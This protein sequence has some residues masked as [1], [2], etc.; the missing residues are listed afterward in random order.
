MYD[1]QTN[2]NLVQAFILF[3]RNKNLNQ[4]AKLLGIS[5]PALSRQ[6]MQFERD[7]GLSLFSNQGRKKVLSA[8]GQ[9]V[10]DKLNSK[11]VDYNEVFIQLR[12]EA[13]NSPVRPIEILGSSDMIGLF[14][15]KINFPFSLHYQFMSSQEVIS[16]LKENK[17]Q[18]GITKINTNRSDLIQK[19]FLKVDFLLLLLSIGCKETNF[20]S[21][22]KFL[23]KR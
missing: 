15:G 11:W 12:A 14:A 17:F 13:Q 18:I 10:F 7:L 20:L 1:M 16:S 5:Q 21:L 8:I 3:G 22:V 4:V 9:Q 2:M 6:L 19:N 23:I